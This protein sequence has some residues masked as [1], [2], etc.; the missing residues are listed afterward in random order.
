MTFLRPTWLTGL[1]PLALIAFAVLGEPL[2]RFTLYAVL[3]A[4]LWPVIMKLGWVYRDKPEFLTYPAAVFA[5][6][7]WSIPLF[8][9]LCAVRY[10]VRSRA[11]KRTPVVR[12]EA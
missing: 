12:R 11:A 9:A 5:A 8:V 6:V 4:P 3:A 7:V 1:P 2:L 10:A